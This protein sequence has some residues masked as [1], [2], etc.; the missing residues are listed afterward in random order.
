MSVLERVE[1]SPE[2]LEA[3]RGRVTAEGIALVD[4]EAPELVLDDDEDEP[5]GPAGPPNPAGDG[6][7]GLGD[8]QVS[9]SLAQVASVATVAP[10]TAPTASP[11]QKG[12]GPE[13]WKRG[14]P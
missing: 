6:Q 7:G 14:P 13:R 9:I 1:L 8:V 5:L 11:P 4:E 10:V 12:P 2:L 3:V